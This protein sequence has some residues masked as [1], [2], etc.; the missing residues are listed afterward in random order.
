M[1]ALKFLYMIH[2]RAQRSDTQPI[3]IVKNS[4][5]SMVISVQK[6]T[7]H[8]NPS[9]QSLSTPPPPK[10]KKKLLGLTFLMP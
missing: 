6:K 9:P 7:K 10:K 2:S 1:V 8:V 5:A 4:V 3:T